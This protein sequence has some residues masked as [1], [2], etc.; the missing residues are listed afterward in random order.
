MI[1][2]NDT[3][4]VGS[5]E[6]DLD[7]DLKIF[8]SCTYRDRNI[9]LCDPSLATAATGYSHTVFIYNSYCLMQPLSSSTLP[10][11]V[12]FPSLR[13]PSASIQDP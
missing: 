10:P 5:E 4:C 3:I 11:D 1:S 8:L 6:A 12:I 9:S 13:K 2:N 7:S